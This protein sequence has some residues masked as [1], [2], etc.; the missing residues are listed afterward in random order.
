MIVAP[1][2]PPFLLFRALSLFEA[3][4]DVKIGVLTVLPSGRQQATPTPV[5]PSPSASAS[6]MLHKSEEAPMQQAPQKQASDDLF[7]SDEFR[8]FCFKVCVV[9]SKTNVLS[10]VSQDKQCF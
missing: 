5:V 2:T 6:G 7:Q 3:S 1:A 4:L 9:E 10:L 8:L